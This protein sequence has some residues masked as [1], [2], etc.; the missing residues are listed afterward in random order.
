MA[1]RM[2][3]A[4]SRSTLRR[5]PDGGVKRGLTM[6]RTTRTTRPSP[7]QREVQRRVTHLGNKSAAQPDPVR[8]RQA[9]DA[10]IPCGS[11][12]HAGQLKVRHR[13]ERS[14]AGAQISPWLSVGGSTVGG[15]ERTA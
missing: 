15:P 5:G 9:G 13:Q 3:S 11:S 2:P 4:D 14:P 6:I 8:P 10:K 1:T 7:A 12:S